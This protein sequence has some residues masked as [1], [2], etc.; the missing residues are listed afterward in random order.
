M[1]NYRTLFLGALSAFSIHH[2]AHALNPPTSF[3]GGGTNSFIFFENNIDQEYLISAEH[4][5]PR[6]TGANVWT[7]YGRDQQDSLGY[8]GTD[9]TLRN[10]NNVDMWLENSS[11]LTPFQGIRC[12]IRNNGACPA[13]GFLPAEFID[14]FGAYKIRSASGD[15]DGGYARASFGPDAYEYLKELAP[16]DVHQFIMHYCE[17]TEDYNPS[18]GGRCKDATTGRWRK[19]QLNITKDAHIKF[20]D[21]RAFSEIWVATDGTPSIAQNS[22]LCRDLVV[23][24]GGTADQREGIAC[25]MVQYDLNGPTSAF[26]NSTHL[27]MAVDQ[28]A[29]NNMAIAAYDLRINAGGNDDWVRYDADTR[30][31]NLMNRMLQSGRHYIE[32]LFTKS[33]FKKMLA[34]EASTSGRRGVFTF[35][36]NNTATPQSGYY[37]FATNMDIDIIPRE[38]GISIRHQNQNERV[39]TGKIGEEDIT[40]NYVVTQS[41]PKTTGANGGRA[42]V[43]KARVL[44]ESTTVR[45][46]SYCLFKSKDEVL[47]VPIPAYLSYTNSAGQ[48][49]EQYS[50]CNASATLDLTDANWNAVPWDQQQSGFFHSTNLD[51]RFP[52]NDR[53]SLFTIDGI[54]W[55]GSV[56]AEGDVEVEATWIGV[57]RPK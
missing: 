43:V 35:A 45:G 16:G 17:T 55:L 23:P 47:Q 21:T 53:V 30:V 18:A 15:F 2:A 22:E 44:G 7:R 46:N 56:R 54:D 25:K 20:I 42:D 24:R 37:Q 26:N 5:N 29:L 8:M 10:R 19:T 57:T 27:Y 14:Q 38:Y 12:R 36:V 41:A 39:K 52:M 33:F 13:T 28:A 51:L 48:K 40:F 34:A 32:V 31:E 4:L 11:M 1:I 9:T 6:F 50:G 49:I 3:T